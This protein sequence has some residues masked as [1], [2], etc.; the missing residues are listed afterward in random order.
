MQQYV[1]YGFIRTQNMIQDGERRARRHVNVGPLPSTGKRWT[2]RTAQS[3]KAGWASLRQLL[4]RS[5]TSP[6]HGGQPAR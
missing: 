4:R 5:T 1:D 6:A 2:Q 3:L